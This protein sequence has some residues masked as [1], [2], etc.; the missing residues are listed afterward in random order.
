MQGS[1][2]M[3][4]KAAAKCFPPTLYFRYRPRP[5]DF[6]PKVEKY[7]KILPRR[8]TS[9]SYQRAVANATQ[10]FKLRTPVKPYHI[11]DSIRHFQHPEKSP[12]LPYT[13][14]GIRQKRDL[15]P[16]DIK[17]KVHNMKYRIGKRDRVPCTAAARTC[18]SKTDPKFRLIWVYPAH[19]TYAEGMF[20]MPLIHSYLEKYGTYGIWIKYAKDHARVLKRKRTSKR[21]QW[22]GLDWNGFDATIPAWLIKDAFQILRSNLDF[23]GYQDYGVPT[24]PYTLPNLWDAIVKYFIDTPIKLPSGKVEVKHQGVPSGSYFTSMVDSV[25]NCIVMHYLLAKL[26]IKY[27]RE[28]FWVVGDDSLTC[29]CSPVD[30]EKLAQLALET[31]GLELNTSKSEL[32]EEVS[33]LGFKISKIGR[34]LADFDKLLGQ[35][36]A[37]SAR[38]T[39]VLDFVSRARA[40]QLAC[41]GIGCMEFTLL[42]QRWLVSH[43]Y[44]A[45]QPSLHHRDELY[46]KLEQL[47]LANWPPLSRVISMVC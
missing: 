33:F 41:F 17:M 16:Y 35:L 8:C 26:H 40:L 3:A 28:A 31:F 39:S 7:K 32:G 43:G 13:R 38:D 30:L 37:P 46:Q 14:M 27:K 29:V 12:G 10:D 44:E 2:N 9:P 15:D 20:A 4:W 25:V 5:W 42:V 36:H 24:H 1:D 18:I 6:I 34:P 23:S 47:D 11:N 21:H 22:L 45:I 19:W